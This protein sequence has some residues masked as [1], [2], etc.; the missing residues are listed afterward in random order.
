MPIIATASSRPATRNICTRSTGSSSGC[1]AEPSMKR[2]PRMPKPIA[3]PSAPMPKMM[4]TAS[5]VMAWICATFSIQLSSKKPIPNSVMLVGH[6]QIDDRQHRKNEGL[7]RD[8]QDVKPRPDE[9]Q[10]EFPDDAQ[11]AAD[12]QQRAESVRQ[13]QHRDQ[14]EDHLSRVQV[15]VEAQRQRHGPGKE[16]HRL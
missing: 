10:R 9:A 15:A 12:A 16:G 7:D 11:P 4:P 6:C 14:Q 8:D 1:R 3:V 2:P 13:R 5:T